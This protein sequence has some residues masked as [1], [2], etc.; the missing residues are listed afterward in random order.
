MIKKLPIPKAIAISISI[1]IV[2]VYFY[3]LSNL[4]LNIPIG[5]DFPAFVDHTE[6]AVNGSLNT[7]AFFS[8]IN[9]HRILYDR[10][11]WITG[12]WLFNSVNFQILI[13]IGNLSLVF[14][15]LFFEKVRTHYA[16][17]IWMSP[18][19]ALVLFSW[20]GYSNS[21]CAMMALQN[22]G[23]PFLV[24]LG[25]WMMSTSKYHLH[26]LLGLF[27]LILAFYTTGIGFLAIIFGLAS[28]VIRK[29]NKALLYCSCISVVFVFLYF[30][31]YEPSPVQ[32]SI[33]SGLSQPV[34]L[35]TRYFAFVGGILPI[36]ALSPL[37]EA[38]LGLMLFGVL[39]FALLRLKNQLPHSLLLITTFF[40]LLAAIVVAARFDLNEYIAN[41]FK[42]NS[43]IIFICIVLLFIKALPK[44]SIRFLSLSAIL[45]FTAALNLFNYKSYNDYRFWVDEF[46]TDLL[47]V[48]YGVETTAFQPKGKDYIRSSFYNR[49]FQNVYSGLKEDEVL[50]QN[51]PIQLKE[52]GSN[53]FMIEGWGNSMF[54]EMSRPAVRIAKSSG[55]TLA[56]L[57]LNFQNGICRDVS[58]IIQSSA[59]CTFFLVDL[60]H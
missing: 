21:L 45:L 19:F 41:R 12:L 2:L 48:N 34:E 60:K 46:A 24:C 22:F 37:P 10:F 8:Q 30:A 33:F 58:G 38:A 29:L 6:A 18:I 56:Y 43:A 1:L 9:E 50:K 40:L 31:F 13:F 4:S 49:A 53:S 7:K 16:L 15:F 20:V 36:S 26:I 51:L 28:L 52:S 42:I 11:F 5:D 54:S 3:S 23:F 39:L 32:S 14:L 25:L 35:L 55:E 17:S 59:G 44:N 27:T 47:N 57:P